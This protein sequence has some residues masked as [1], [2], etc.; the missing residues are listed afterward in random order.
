M[1]SVYNDYINNVV[2]IADEE[3]NISEYEYFSSSASIEASLEA[4]KADANLSQAIEDDGYDLFA[5][6]P[7]TTTDIQDNIAPCQGN[8][9]A[10]SGTFYIDGTNSCYE[11]TT[12]TF[13]E[14]SFDV[15]DG[16]TIPRDQLNVTQLIDG[17]FVPI[18]FSSARCL[19]VVLK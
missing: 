5:E 8:S 19:M 6:P 14:I 16:I 18:P 3:G 2:Y 7:V 4:Q 1:F 10:A 15:A 11:G 17:E 13:D 9:D 12:Y